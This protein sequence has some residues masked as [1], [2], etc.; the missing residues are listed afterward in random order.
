MLPWI[1]TYTYKCV[2]N[3]ASNLIGQHSQLYT[4]VLVTMVI[5]YH[6]QEVERKWPG[7]YD[8]L[9]SLSIV[10]EEP[11]KRINMAHLAIVGSHA[12]NGVAA[13]HSGLLKTTM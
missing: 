3:A 8:R 10:E 6:I 7:D 9:R 4:L 11:H 5:S 1:H 12:V 2:S 13:I